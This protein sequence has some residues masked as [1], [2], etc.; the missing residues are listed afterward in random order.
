[1]LPQWVILATLA[2]VGSNVFNFI[3]RFLLKEKGDATTWAWTFETLRLIVFVILAIF[4]FRIQ[5]NLHTL[6]LLS[7]I[8]LTEVISVFLYMKMHQYSHLSISTILSRTRVIWIPILGFLFLGERLTN[9][10]YIGI[11]ILFLGL[12]I[13]VSP[14]KLFLDKGAI[15][16]NLASFVIAINTILQK[17]VLPYASIPVIMIFF[18][19]PSVIIFPFLMK[20]PKKRLMDENRQHLIPKLIAV[21][22]NAVASILL[23]IA[24]KLGEVSRVNAVYQGMLI[25]G[26]LAGII[27]LNE[28]KDIFRKLLGTTVTIIGV[29]LLTQYSYIRRSKVASNQKM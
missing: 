19:L 22:V 1:M 24:L 8:G 15:Y 17:Q 12:S 2:G 7:L 26:V 25:I 3:S 5:F 13:A 14:H 21:L 16:A 9:I 23:L 6:I 27:F 20:N 29:I 28:R 10:E 18:S 11:V 4:D